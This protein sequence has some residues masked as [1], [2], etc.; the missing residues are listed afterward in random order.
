MKSSSIPGQCIEIRIRS[1]SGAKAIH[2]TNPCYL[3]S[4]CLSSLYFREHDARDALFMISSLAYIVFLAVC[5]FFR[6][7]RMIGRGVNFKP[8]SLVF[9][10][11]KWIEE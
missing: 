3:I 10:L 2:K 11:V 4:F 5:D 7:T 8:F 9:D 6:M 1:P